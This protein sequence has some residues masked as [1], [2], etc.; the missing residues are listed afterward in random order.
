MAQADL[1]EAASAALA[2][3]AWVRR[4]IDDRVLRQD[5]QLDDVLEALRE[6]EGP[7]LV[8]EREQVTVARL[9]AESPT[10]RNSRAVP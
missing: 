9:H 7:V 6:V 3:L 5:E 8:E 2:G 4:A 10:C 1:A